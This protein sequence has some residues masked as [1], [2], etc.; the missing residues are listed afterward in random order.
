GDLAIGGRLHYAPRATFSGQTQIF[1]TV[2]DATG[3]ASRQVVATVTVAVYG[4]PTA[5]T[6]A[7][8]VTARTDTSTNTPFFALDWSAGPALPKGA[9]IDHYEVNWSGGDHVDE[10]C[11]G[12]GP[13]CGFS[14]L[15]FARVYS[16]RVRA[17]DVYDEA[18]PWGP[19][20]AAKRYDV[21]PPAVSG[22]T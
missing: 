9:A 1:V 18:G 4:P 11:A 22:A 21:A 12:S 8:T 16:F 10:T 13:R 15:S 7:P 14:G 6:V 3:I 20:S 17:V 19:A 5:P 2:G